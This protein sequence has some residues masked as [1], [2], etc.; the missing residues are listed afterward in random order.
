[1]KKVLIYLV[2]LGILL[3]SFNVKAL[4]VSKSSLTLKPGESDTSS[5]YVNTE[6]EITSID[7][8]FVY[9]SYDVPASFKVADG[10]TDNTSGVYHSITFTE[11]QKGKILLGTITTNV[12]AEPKGKTGTT[13]I[14]NASAKDT[15]GNKINL[16]SASIQTTIDLPTPEPEPTPVVTPE[17]ES[18]SEVEEPKVE[19]NE[20]KIDTDLLTSIESDIVKITLIPGVYNYN[21]YI[22]KNIQEL[23]LKGIAKTPD[24]EVTYTTQK[25]SELEDNKIVIT[26]KTSDAESI[27]NIKVTIKEDK[28]EDKIVEEEKTSNYKAKWVIIILLMSI[29]LGVSL[30]FLKVKSE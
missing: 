21:I 27:Y 30:L 25:I 18:T 7:F 14:N 8:A 29:S 9:K 20:L 24:T 15:E 2:F 23:D 28:A 12:V 26:A 11:P 17:P 4:E 19:E 6:T 22:D 1:M 10:L 16:S 3:V 13:N 5:L